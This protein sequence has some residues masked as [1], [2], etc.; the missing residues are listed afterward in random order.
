MHR[1]F[2]FYADHIANFT[3]MSAT[4]MNNEKKRLLTVST[5]VTGMHI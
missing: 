4:D 5:M 1:L 3:L 2:M